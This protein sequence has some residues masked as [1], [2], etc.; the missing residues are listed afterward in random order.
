MGQGKGGDELDVGRSVALKNQ[1]K[2]SLYES[3]ISSQQM[4][5]WIVDINEKMI[6]SEG[7]WCYTN[8][9]VRGL[10]LWFEYI[11]QF[12]PKIEIYCFGISRCSLAAINV[13]FI[14]VNSHF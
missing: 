13:F 12:I 7:R 2:Q 6:N 5:R 3:H 14:R 10:M 4:K 1:P 8:E 11:L 9:C